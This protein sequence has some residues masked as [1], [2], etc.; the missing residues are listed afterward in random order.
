[1]I[2]HPQTSDSLGSEHSND[3]AAE[4][5]H[6]GAVPTTRRPR[7]GSAASAERQNARDGRELR[8]RCRGD[9]PL[10]ALDRCNARHPRT[11]ACAGARMSPVTAVVPMPYFQPSYRLTTKGSPSCRTHSIPRS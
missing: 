3:P 7:I 6:A 9:N 5:G 10:A 1:M 2:S 11:F 4:A 8:F